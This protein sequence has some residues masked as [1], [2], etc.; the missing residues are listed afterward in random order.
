MLKAIT[1]LFKTLFTD[2]ASDAGSAQTSEDHFVTLIAIAGE[3]EAIR[4]QLI[5][6]LSL[7]SFDRISS[8]N[9]WIDE[10]RLAQAPRPLIDAL[11]YLL[12]DD[13]ADRALA[14]LNDPGTR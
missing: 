6:I 13:T 10:I 1:N 4:Q 5:S 7:N 3:D 11:T 12:D 14:L 2:T 8:L 9:T